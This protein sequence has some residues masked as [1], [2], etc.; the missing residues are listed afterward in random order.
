MVLLS[1]M[2]ASISCE[3]EDEFSFLQ[4]FKPVRKGSPLSSLSA[5]AAVTVGKSELPGS[6]PSSDKKLRQEMRRAK[7]CVDGCQTSCLQTLTVSPQTLPAWIRA[8]AQS[9]ARV[10]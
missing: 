7:A 6:M 5:A 2:T 3:K 8:G 1:F 9:A 10:S 4:A